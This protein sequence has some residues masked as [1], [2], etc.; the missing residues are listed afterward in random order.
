MV[1][2]SAHEQLLG[3]CA[4]KEPSINNVT[5]YWGGTEEGGVNYLTG[6]VTLC[7]QDSWENF[8]LLLGFTCFKVYTN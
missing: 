1:V 2:H 6:K 5:C 7:S 3:E 8:S 4:L